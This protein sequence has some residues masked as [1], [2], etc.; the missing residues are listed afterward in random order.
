MV[1]EAEST[2][3]EGEGWLQTQRVNDGYRGRG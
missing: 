2:D 3:V 1:T